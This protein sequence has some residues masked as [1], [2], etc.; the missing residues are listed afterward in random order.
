MSDAT[1]AE[2][3]DLIAAASEDRREFLRLALELG[4]DHKTIC[5]LAEATRVARKTTIVLPS[6]KYEHLSRGRGWARLGKGISAQWGERVKNGYEVGP[7]RWSVGST[8]GFKRKS[9]V[10]WDVKNIQVGP[11][12]WTIAS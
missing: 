10:V 2:M 8:D 11:E 12:T 7:G 6:G 1:T 3:T 5:L 4:A 9:A